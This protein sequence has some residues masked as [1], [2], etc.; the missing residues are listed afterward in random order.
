APDEAPPAARRVAPRPIPTA[1]I[2]TQLA[3]RAP[4]AGPEDAPAEAPIDEAGREAAISAVLD[5]IIA[6]PDAAF[7]SDAVLYQDF[8]VR[9]RIRRVP[10]AP[11][12]LAAFR[13]RLAV[14]RAGVDASIEGEAWTRALALSETLPDDVQGVF[15]LLARAAVREEPC[16][17][18]ATL[19]RVY[20]SHSIR[21]SRRLLSYFEER[22]LLVVRV[23]FHGRRVIAFPDL[24]R[25]TAPGDADAPEMPQPHAAE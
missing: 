19:A 22:G 23:D 14:A 9:S 1:D 2:L 11:I 25:E 10:G 20:G 12:P 21:R 16:P 24:D 15:L 8:L 17:S 7:R 6:D 13:R 18:D 3:R 4:E 5:E